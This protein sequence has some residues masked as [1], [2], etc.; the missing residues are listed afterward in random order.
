MVESSN[1]WAAHTNVL[2]AL[3]AV[4]MCTSPAVHQLHLE[5]EEPHAIPPLG[6][7]Q[8][9]AT[10]LFGADWLQQER[11]TQPT[12]GGKV[13]PSS[14]PNQTK[15]GW[16]APYLDDIPDFP[17][18]SPVCANPHAL[19][20]SEALSLYGETETDVS[21]HEKELRAMPD[22]AFVTEWGVVQESDWKETDATKKKRAQ[23]DP[24]GAPPIKRVKLQDGKPAA[25][26]D[27]PKLTH[28]P[29]VPSFLPP[30]PDCGPGRIIVADDTTPLVPL[31]PASTA[32]S[33]NDT[34]GVRSSLVKMEQDYWGSGWD[35]REPSIKV[36][37]GRTKT[38]GTTPPTVVVPLVRA[39]GSRIS[40]ILEGSMD[41]TH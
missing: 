25:A 24:E 27:T 9:L 41:A 16:D 14:V 10:F 22:E 40:R 26:Q 29:Y 23:E 3:R 30:F 5:G 38:E 19:P 20:R 32:S 6:G 33:T 18:A 31:M 28:P 35:E 34:L 8:D 17:Q 2:D 13:G 1:R 15:L 21:Q 12:A 37:L 4:D 7:W 11:N 39:S 36:P